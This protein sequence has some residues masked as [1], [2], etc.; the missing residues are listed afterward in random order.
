LVWGEKESKKRLK[1]EL[2]AVNLVVN[3]GGIAC[4][5]AVLLKPSIIELSSGKRSV[6][7]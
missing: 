7:W 6:I 3:G 2:I 1:A 4:N 5:P